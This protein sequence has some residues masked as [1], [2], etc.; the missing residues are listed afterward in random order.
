MIG[1]LFYVTIVALPC[2]AHRAVSIHRNYLSF[3]DQLCSRDH[4]G[5]DGLRLSSK[6]ATCKFEQ[7][8]VFCIS[9]VL[10]SFACANKSS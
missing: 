1:L 8:A 3:R 6:M 5:A 2:V 7:N 9:F 10:T 4:G